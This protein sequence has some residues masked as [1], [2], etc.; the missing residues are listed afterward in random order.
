[1]TKILAIDD[2][3][4]NLISLKAIIEDT[5]PEAVILS[6]SN[7]QEGIALAVE[8]NPDVILLDIIMPGMD[9]FEVCRYLKQDERVSDIPVVFLTALRGDKINRI[10]ALEAGG[11]G[12]LSKPIDEVELKAQIRAM[13]KIN[14]S[15]KLKRTERDR[16][17]GLVN[18]HTKELEESEARF[19]HISSSISDIS[20]S[21]K[22]ESDGSSYID[23]LYGP[24]EKLT[25]YTPDELMEMK[26]WGKLVL[27]EDFPTFKK[28]VL[29]V[30][31]GKSDMCELRLERKDGKIIWITASAE[32]VE[33]SEKS[34]VLY[35]AL[36]NITEKKI[37][38]AKLQESEIFF[39]DTQRSAYIGSYRYS[40][41]QDWWSSSEIFDQ[42]FGIDKDYVRTFMGWLNLVY[43]EDKAMMF[44]YFNDEVLG[45]RKQF[46]KEYRVVRQSDREV[47][48]VLGLGQLNQNSEG[49]IIEMIGTIQDITDRKV[50]TEALKQSNELNQSLLQ[51]IPY[52]IDIVDETG[53]I[54]FLNERLANI[55]GTDALGQKCW[56]VYR[57]NRKQCTGCPIHKSVRIGET[58][59][60]ETDGVLGGRTFQISH[61]PMIFQ[62]KT[63]M[64]EIFQDVTERKL[65]EEKIRASENKFSNIF[66]LS[67]DAIILIK[68]D[69]KCIS[70]VN[71]SCCKITGYSREE[72]I[73]RTSTELQLWSDSSDQ[74]RFNELIFKDCS[75]VNL[76]A[77]F[78]MKSGEVKTG[79]LSS[80]LIDLSNSKYTLIIIRDITFRKEI[81]N[82][83]IA[84]KEK[85]EESDRLKSAFLANMSHE[86]RTPLN[87]IIGF[88][89]LLFDPDFEA[90]Q[91]REF[92]QSINENG[93][94]L[95]SI[96]TDIIDISK[97]ESGLISIE[98]SPF[99]VLDLL[100]SVIREFDRKASKKGV[101]LRLFYPESEKGIILHGD[102]TKVRQVLTNLVGNAIK[103]TD[104]GYVEIGF[105]KIG[106]DLRFHVKDSGIGIQAEF[107]KQIF[108]R[109]RQVDSSYSRKYGGNGLGLAISRSYIEKMDGRIWVESEVGK[110][111]SFFFTVPTQALEFNKS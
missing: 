43:S 17:Q 3:V 16:L 55:V 73:G 33:K 64:L 22:V 32:C 84:A 102:L 38:E 42:I 29:E 106:P 58:E 109:F 7:G 74:D 60:Y 83:L 59:I 67:P 54:L 77:N 8:N 57:D 37:A 49:E 99:M 94:N 20:Y 95:L 96:L 24:T 56:K 100:K 82:E 72:L 21:C 28:H 31:A 41:S 65:M 104:E 15:N 27:K 71:E 97:I 14:E 105:E 62:G 103:F 53:T 107:Q 69:S 85:A 66:N 101:E 98:R 10:K 44:S 90:S 87:S 5:F 23:W 1:M 2:I 111:A 35:G 40:V 70:E 26:C 11:E 6:A 76:E 52:G 86:I 68:L 92:V 45:E 75:V 30:P 39:K 110:G 48:W 18:E 50:V 47:R 51:T 61:T 13:L 63:A 19:R 34:A 81:E 12:F 79:L 9:G 25:G 4:D 89:E 80:S 108:E 93:N 36:I 78:M 46:N 91:K 88:S